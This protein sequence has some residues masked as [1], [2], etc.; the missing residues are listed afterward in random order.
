VYGLTAEEAKPYLNLPPGKKL[1][2]TGAELDLV[3]L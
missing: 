3:D 2:Q 1:A